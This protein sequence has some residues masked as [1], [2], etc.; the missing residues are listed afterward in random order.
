MVTAKRAATKPPNSEHDGAV[1]APRKSPFPSYRLKVV[2]G[3]NAAVVTLSCSQT[4]RRRDVWLGA[5]DSPESRVAYA[6]AIAEWESTGRVLPVRTI[7]AGPREITVAQV[8]AAYT[9]HADKCYS[10]KHAA[11]IRSAT[12]DLFRLFGESPANAIGPN[13]LRSLRETLRVPADGRRDWSRR[14]VN[15]AIRLILQMF[16]WAASREL[17]QASQVVALRMIE[18]LKREPGESAEK[19][20]CVPVK[21][22]AAARKRVPLQIAAMID[23]QLLTGMRPG[24]VCNLRTIDIDRSGDVWIARPALHKNAHRGIRREIYIGPKARRIIKQFARGNEHAAL[25]SPRDSVKETFDRRH[26]WRVTPANE[27]N[28][29]GKVH[30]DSPSR[31]PG[32]RYTVDSYRHAINRACDAAKVPQWSP[33]Q[34]RHN[35]ATEIRKR[36]GLEAAQILLGHSSALVTDAVYAERDG[37]KA[38]AIAAECG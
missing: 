23:L 14:T 31:P 13:A 5:Y 8:I 3:K 28:G 9:R 10:A 37:A 7:A 38:A 22:I 20:G 25:F 16:R 2:R 33:N 32:T 11:F 17:I 4:G 15:R 6:S 24:E 18:P 12:T 34:L 19:V 27:G 36:Y 21:S 26:A 35:Y 1:R 30:T 29:R